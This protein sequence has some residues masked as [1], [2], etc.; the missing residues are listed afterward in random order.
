MSTAVELLLP[1]CGYVFDT[2]TDIQ[3]KFI[4]KIE[5][6]NTDV[7][8]E[9]LKT[10]KNSELSYPQTLK[11]V[12]SG[13]DGGF[14]ELSENIDFIN[15]YSV[16]CDTP[17]CEIDNLKVATKYYWRVNGGEAH[18]FY[19]KDNVIRFI[20]ID[21]LLN[22]RDI[23]GKN[24]KQGLIYRGSDLDLVYKISEKGKET[25]CNQLGIKT[26]VD[27][28]KEADADRPC[29]LGDRVCLKSLPYR[30][31]SEVF[32]EEHR[33]GIC[34]IMNFLSDEKNYP[35]YIHCLGGAD[36][37]G[38]IAFYLRALAGECDELIH[39]DYELTSLST[40]AYGLAEGAGRDGFRNRNSDYYLN[41]LAMLN[42]YAPGSALS[43]KVRAFLLDCGV[44]T[45]CIDK[46]LSIIS[47]KLNF[48]NS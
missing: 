44:E 40:Y 2:H 14:F 22:V 1:P 41:F 37:T 6:C 34:R 7:A 5:K 11:F 3:N 4:E 24:I 38:M 36:R 45:E 23:G 16:E 29:A 32:E 20:K 21:G 46:I 10:V 12:W 43:A 28:R 17:F 8:I 13:V 30:P 26:E 31:Y 47:V 18:Y 15:A 19:T 33:Q 27:L 25:F 35:V 39:L 48:I 9:W 42:E